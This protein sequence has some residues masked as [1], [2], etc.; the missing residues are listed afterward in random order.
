ML[1][2]FI[3]NIINPSH[4]I[5]LTKIQENLCHMLLIFATNDINQGI[6]TNTLIARIPAGYIPKQPFITPIPLYITNGGVGFANPF[7]GFSG[8]VQIATDGQI[9]LDT[10]GNGVTVRAGYLSVLYHV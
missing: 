4:K 8:F 6:T 3:P 2:D 10:Y 1:V 5:K 7:V 9:S